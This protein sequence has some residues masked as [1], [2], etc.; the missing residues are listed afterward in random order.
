[1]TQKLTGVAILQPAGHAI[2]GA[3]PVLSLM[4]VERNGSS[5]FVFGPSDLKR[6]GIDFASE[7]I[8]KWERAPTLKY[9]LPVARAAVSTQTAADVAEALVRARAFQGSDGALVIK[10]G[11][12][13]AA[14]WL[15]C[16]QS[17][18]EQAL[19]RMT[20]WASGEEFWKLTEA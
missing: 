19:V 12:P 11:Q 13:E 7:N 1:M 20:S 16:L 10:P 5:T 17:W 18:R 2:G 6:L 9:S 4:P 3:E 14:T 15:S 8:E